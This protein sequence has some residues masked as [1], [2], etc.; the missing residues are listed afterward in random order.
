MGAQLLDS[1]G[2][3]AEW[4]LSERKLTKRTF[5]RTGNPGGSR[6]KAEV[7]STAT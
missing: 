7:G 3:E 1:L 6:P 5:I 2:P 4:R